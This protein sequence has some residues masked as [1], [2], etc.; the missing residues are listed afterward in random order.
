MWYLRAK[1]HFDP[2]GRHVE[3]NLLVL[4]DP[5][6][7]GSAELLEQMVASGDWVQVP[8]GETLLPDEVG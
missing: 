6:G 7:A 2:Q 1:R 3:L 8:D 5:G 4:L